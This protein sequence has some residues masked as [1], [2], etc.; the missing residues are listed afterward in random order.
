MSEYEC[1]VTV[2]NPAGE[3]IGSRVVEIDGSRIGDR[4]SAA[5][6]VKVEVIWRRNTKLRTMEIPA[7]R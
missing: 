6:V 1:V 5:N 3:V 7:G 2:T 4:G